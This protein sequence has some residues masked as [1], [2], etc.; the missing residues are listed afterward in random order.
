MYKKILL[1]DD[2]QEDV[3]LLQSFITEKSLSIQLT[4]A[5]NGEKLIDLLSKMP[6]PDLILLDL[7]L[8]LKNGK[9]CLLEIR[10]N[11]EFNN[12]P[13]AIYS[14]SDNKAIIDFCM[15]NKANHYF[16]KPH[17]YSGFVELAQGL[18][19]GKLIDNYSN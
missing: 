16:V 9:Q 15:S 6:R 10:S 1:A 3:E 12:I 14:G 5:Q 4:I 8:P 17:T 11:T 18:G 19:N 2:D 7:H 13:I